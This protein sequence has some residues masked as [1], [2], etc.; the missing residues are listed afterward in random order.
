V[1]R[2]AAGLEK[3]VLRGRLEPE[4]EAAT[5][6]TGRRVLA[7]AGIGRPEKFFE[8]LKACGAIVEA[9]RAFPDHHPFSTGD[10]AAL[11]RD[12][13]SRGLAL[14]T[15]EKDAARIGARDLAD[16]ILALPVRLRLEDEAALRVLLEAALER[17]RQSSGRG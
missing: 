11:R 16:A 10:L 9:E 2:E 5:R 15:T 12:A 7:F 6:L 1:A 14:V 13:G 4:P 17:A 3:P 8:T